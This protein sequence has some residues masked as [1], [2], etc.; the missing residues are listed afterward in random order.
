MPNRMTS[1]R[2]R[3]EKERDELADVVV[4]PAAFADGGDDRSQVVVGEHDLGRLARCLRAAPAHRD[5]D[6]GTAKRGGR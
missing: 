2:I 1:P 4:D 6:V 5:S 3:R